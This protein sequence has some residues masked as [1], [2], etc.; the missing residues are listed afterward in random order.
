MG[1]LS[2]SPTGFGTWAWGNQLLWDYQESIDI[3][4]S[5]YWPKQL[6][7][8]RDYL[9]AQRSAIAPAQVA[10]HWCICKGT[11]PILV[12]KSVKQAEENLGALGWQLNSD[13]LL[14]LENEALES[15]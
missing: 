15:P 5:N 4:V 10:I 6:L 14:Q 13:K 2:E 3:G 9:R 7:K 11:I 12:V 1:P 8:I